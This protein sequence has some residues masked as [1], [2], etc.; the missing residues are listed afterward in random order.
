MP[1]QINYAQSLQVFELHKH[2]IAKAGKLR[3]A[4]RFKKCFIILS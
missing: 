3:K 4:L 2:N 1:P